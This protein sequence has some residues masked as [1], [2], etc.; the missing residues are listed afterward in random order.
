MCGL[1]IGFNALFASAVPA[2]LRAFVVG[3]RNMIQSL[4]F[5][6]ASVGTGY[7]LD[8]VRFPA[9]YQLI[10][11]IGFLSAAMS[12]LHLFFIRPQGIP[13][14]RY[15]PSLESTQTVK[16]KNSPR[17]WHT[18]LHLDIWRTPYR[19]VLLVLLGFHFTQYIPFPLFPLYVVNKL[20]LSDA[21]I[22]LATAFFYLTVLLGSTQLNRLVNKAGHHRLTGWGVIAMSLYPIAMSVSQNAFHYYLLSIAGGFAWALVGGAYANYLLERVPENDRPFHLAW[23]NIVL[24]AA[25]LLAS[26]AGPFIANYIGL[27]TALFLF[28]ILRLLAGIAILKWG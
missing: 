1:G 27:G 9:G 8:H 26:M 13:E 14:P 20:H 5:M 24:N 17:D 21:N 25:V 16:K 6:V 2:E 3:R 15:G 22:G 7:I 12:T 28:G 18:V 11:G 19:K 4:T 23:Y 10:F